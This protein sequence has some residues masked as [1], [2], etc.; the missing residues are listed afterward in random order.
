M[1]V[2][3]ME[4]KRILVIGGTGYIGESVVN[5]FDKEGYQVVVLSRNPERYESGKRIRRIK[6][7][8]LNREFLLKNLKDFDAVIY[9]AAIV[10]TLNKSKYEENI[11][12][13]KNTIEAMRVNKINK[14]LYFSTQ[15]VYLKKTGP[16]GNSKKICEEI[17]C[18]A[19]LDYMI[20]RPNYVYGIDTR[21]DFYKLYKIM[22]KTGICPI[23]GSGD[24]KIQPL[25]KNDLAEITLKC[26]E[27]W[28]SKGEIDVSGRTTISI[29]QIAD[30]IKKQANLK[31]ISFHIP[32]WLL[33]ICAWAVPFDVDGYTEDRI[34]PES[35]NTKKGSADI[36]EDIK[37]MIKS[38]LA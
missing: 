2:I 32:V 10:R 36:E 8:V 5:R 9:L 29:N 18:R 37:K 14:I 15:N 4:N 12:G 28:K 35:A 3:K 30:A 23:I 31:C 33:R 26:M 7:S 22:K 19:A 1:E 17:I 11:I 24:T 16:Y 38:C 27:E 20:I 25:N 34:S 6:G 13:L 21:N